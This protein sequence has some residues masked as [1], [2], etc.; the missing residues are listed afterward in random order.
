MDESLTIKLSIKQLERLLYETDHVIKLD[1]EVDGQVTEV[2][3]QKTE[4]W[5]DNE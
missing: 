4:E 2:T 5:S 3:I 1:V